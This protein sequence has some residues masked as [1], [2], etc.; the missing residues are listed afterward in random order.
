MKFFYYIV[1]SIAVLIFS[2]SAQIFRGYYS[3][4][5]VKYHSPDDDKHY[6]I[7]G[8]YD[9]GK[10]E[11][12]ANYKK[13][14]LDG[15][16]KEYYENGVLKAEVNFRNGRRHGLARFYYDDG[17]I[18]A[19]VIYK[20]GKETTGARY[21]NRQGKVKKSISEVKRDVRIPKRYE[22]KLNAND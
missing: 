19:K 15:I 4:G 12:V 18:M 10:L 8:Y 14:E 6:S 21:Y 1:L 22:E 3:D 11:Y 9:N 7:S 5:V 2:T 17:T 20:R 13:D 16:T